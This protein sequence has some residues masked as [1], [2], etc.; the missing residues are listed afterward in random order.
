MQYAHVSRRR[1]AGA[2]VTVR[3]PVSGTGLPSVH[4]VAP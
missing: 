4:G 2:V 3:V 1:I